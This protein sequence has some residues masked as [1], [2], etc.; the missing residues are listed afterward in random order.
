MQLPRPAHVFAVSA[1]FLGFALVQVCAV[2]A[3]GIYRLPWL[4]QGF[5]ALV[6]V[7][8]FMP[9]GEALARRFSRQTFDRLILAALA[10]LGAKLLTGL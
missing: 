2:T 4:A 5:F 1:M 8:A 9:V 6:P 3:A 7:L 10:L